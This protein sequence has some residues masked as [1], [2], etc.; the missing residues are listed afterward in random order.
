M[1]VYFLAC[2]PCI[3]NEP[4][5]VDMGT[6][7]VVSPQSSPERI[8]IFFHGWSGSPAQYIGKKSINEA[9]DSEKVMLIL[10]KG[11]QE[12][13]SMDNMGGEDSYRDEDAFVQQI[14]EDVYMK[15][16]GESL[17]IYLGG[18]SLGGALSEHLACYGSLDIAGVHPISGGFWD[19]VPEACR[20]D[21]D[22][23]HVHGLNDTTWPYAG[24]RVGSGTQAH[25]EDIQA[26]WKQNSN[27]S[28]EQEERMDGPLSCTYWKGCS[29]I[30]SWCIHQEGHTRLS[31]WFSRMVQSMSE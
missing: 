18:F 2:S 9:V 26:L 8:L 13:W 27:C 12:T 6:Y 15:N 20:T 3:E 11:K 28:D 29:N 17:P 22:I 31:G 19:P 24:R 10:P 16:G 30:V 23:R 14:M 1:I 5:S 4:C 7:H 21:F 25:Q